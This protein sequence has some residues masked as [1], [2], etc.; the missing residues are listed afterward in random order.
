MNASRLRRRL[1][2]T[3]AV[4]VLVGAGVLAAA[5][6]AVAKA[7]LLTIDDVALKAPGVQVKVTYS[8][9]PGMNHQL[10]ANA[11]KQAG[12][13]GSVAAGTLKTDKLTCDY[14]SHTAQIT[15]RPAVGST[16]DKGDKVKVAI[17]YFD[18]DGFSYARQETVV[19]L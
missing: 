19:V 12:H 5:P 8:C 1:A 9:D 4:T 7:N 13:D 14:S 16:F 10:V 18:N 15:M 3:A 6:S 11:A 17:F 2:G